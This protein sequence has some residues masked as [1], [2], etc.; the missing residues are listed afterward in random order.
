MPPSVRVPSLQVGPAHA[1]SAGVPARVDAPVVKPEPRRS[2]SAVERAGALRRARVRAATDLLASHRDTVGG[3]HA[4]VRSLVDTA[5]ARSCETCSAV[6]ALRAH[7][8][9]STSGLT[10]ES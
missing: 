4:P 7:D 5:L 6:T 10:S 8:Q 9:R 1:G 2:H 3:F